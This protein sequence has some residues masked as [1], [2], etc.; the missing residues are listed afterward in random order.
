MRRFHVNMGVLSLRV[1]Q[2]LP[3]SVRRMPP[4]LLAPVLLLCTS[5]TTVTVAQAPGTTAASSLCPP[6]SAFTL[7]FRCLFHHQPEELAASVPSPFTGHSVPGTGLSIFHQYLATSRVGSIM[8][9]GLQMEKQHRGVHCWPRVK[10]VVSLGV[11]IQIQMCLS[12]GVELLALHHPASH[13][14][15]KLCLFLGAGSDHRWLSLQAGTPWFVVNSRT[16]HRIQA[17]MCAFHT[18]HT[19]P[20]TASE[21]RQPEPPAGSVPA[22]RSPGPALVHAVPS[23]CPCRRPCRIVPGSLGPQTPLDMNCP[24]STVCHS[25]GAS[26]ESPTQ[27]QSSPSPM[28]DLRP[29]APGCS[30]ARSVDAVKY[31]AEGPPAR[32]ELRNSGC[33]ASCSGACVFSHLPLSHPLPTH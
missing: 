28:P 24:V 19:P 13:R 25:W 5:A 29:H 22:H 21:Q 14:S 11:G 26:F 3:L 10:P 7:H 8:I 30:P 2:Q 12:P 16:H 1:D 20:P 9:P 6:H 15:G 27:W 18:P 32:C 33:I 23:L 17:V 31:S 4:G